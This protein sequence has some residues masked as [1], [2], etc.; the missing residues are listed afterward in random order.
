MADM[1]ALRRDLSQAISYLPREVVQALGDTAQTIA[2]KYR[3]HLGD[4]LPKVLELLKPHVMA[5]GMEH[6]MGVL[7]VKELEATV[8][9]SIAANGV[10]IGPHGG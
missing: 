7:D 5:L 9:A 1:D 4:V 10:N 6:A 2:V 8:L 3:D